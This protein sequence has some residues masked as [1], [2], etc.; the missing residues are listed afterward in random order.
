[1]G[2]V[3]NGGNF[4]SKNAGS[5]S[6]TLT[7]L[8]LEGAD[9]GNYSFASG[10]VS[11]T[12]L[13]TPR[14]VTASFGALDK[15]YDGTRT[16][17]LTGGSLSG[18]LSEDVVSVGVASGSFADE[19]VSRDASGQVLAQGVQVDGVSLSGV[20]AGNYQVVAS[21]GSARI[22]PKV[23][24]AVVTAQDKV[25]DG[26]QQ[27]QV[28]GSLSGVL[29]GDQVVL[30]LDSKSLFASKNVQSDANGLPVAQ[31]VTVSGL[32]LTGAQALNYDLDSANATSLAKITP[33]PLQA[34]AAV[35][36]KTY[37]GTDQAF[38]TGL[39]GQGV[40]AGDDVRLEASRAV[41]AGPDVALDAQNQVLAQSVSVKGV[42]MLGA[43]AGNY[44]LAGEGSD[45]DVQA[46]IVPR[47][48]SLDALAQDKMYDGTRAAVVRVGPLTGLVGQQQL[49]LSVQA[50]FDTPD[51]GSNKPV[52]VRYTLSDG[53][54]GLARNYT[55]SSPR[56]MA[57]IR[58]ETQGKPVQPMVMPSQASAKP[59]SVVF[60]P[61]SSVAAAQ[62]SVISQDPA[63]T[64]PGSCRP[65][66][67]GECVCEDTLLAEVQL[68]YVPH[69][70]DELA[71]VSRR[72]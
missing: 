1:V 41:F 23:L 51:V 11:G 52:D 58:S 33:K 2:V 48:L 69:S 34:S 25:Y 46:R 50:E 43:D 26:S 30:G 7:G 9:R 14:Q 54:G 21:A 70:A 66:A 56:L 19:N 65:E 31:A 37:D 29:G 55:L 62:A 67:M 35:S 18:V 59:L 38:L 3:S 64:T 40:V 61:S 39:N 49:G 45:L 10:N 15:V 47:Q 16:A 53:V 71:S 42:R 13:I 27:A 28:V 22:T 20:D 17:I 24:T 32:Q 72:P 4:A 6:F 60:V 12:G 63:A 36:D 57:S 44:S 5:Q 68:C 8:Q